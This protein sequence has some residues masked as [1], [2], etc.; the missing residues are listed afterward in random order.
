MED[1]ENISIYTTEGTKA[2]VA[3]GEYTGAFINVLVGNLP[4]SKRP[5]AGLMISI[6]AAS[7]QSYYQHLLGLATDKDGISRESAEENEGCAGCWCDSCNNL[8]DCPGFPQGDG[9]TPPPC[10]ACI[11]AAP[12]CSARYYKPLMPKG[13]VP[14]CDS[15]ERVET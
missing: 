13:G 15:Y 2:G 6:A 8:P 10:A 4:E 7:F 1:K 12:E 5:S 9:I 11:A 14:A 3:F